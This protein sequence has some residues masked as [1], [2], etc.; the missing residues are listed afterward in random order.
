MKKVLFWISSAACS[1]LL[2]L[3]L[4]GY[5]WR[6]LLIGLS[7]CAFSILAAVLQAALLSKNKPA[8]Q[9]TGMTCVSCGQPIAAEGS[10][11]CWDCQNKVKDY[12]ENV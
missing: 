11:L 6:A 10:H 4:V 7:G 8:E 2:V 5:G 1:T 9:I 3:L 12:G